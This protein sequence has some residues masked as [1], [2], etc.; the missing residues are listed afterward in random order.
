MKDSSLSSD[1]KISL[2]LRSAEFALILD[3][4]LVVVV[5]TGSSLMKWFF[6]YLEKVFLNGRA[7]ISGSISDHILGPITFIDLSLVF[8]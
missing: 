6:K 8:E 3:F 1:S 2:Q 4:F 7:L 5:A